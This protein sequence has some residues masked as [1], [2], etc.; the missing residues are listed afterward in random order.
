MDDPIVNGIHA[1][2]KLKIDNNNDTN[3]TPNKKSNDDII[4][5]NNFFILFHF[6]I[7]CFI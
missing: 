6:P 2:I 4:I 7:T 5:I 1:F 3:E